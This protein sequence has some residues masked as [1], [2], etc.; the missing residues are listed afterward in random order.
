MKDPQELQLELSSVCNA[1]CAFCKR[2]EDLGFMDIEL[3]KGI[4]REF[5]E[6]KEI[7]PWFVGESM[8]H[9]RFIE[10]VEFI[11]SQRKRIV[12]YSNGSLL[13]EEKCEAMVS[14]G[15]DELRISVEGHEKQLYESLRIGLDFDTVRENIERYY[16]RKRKGMKLTVRVGIVPENHNQINEIVAFWKKR[17]DHVF[18][19]NEMPIGERD[20]CGEYRFNRCHQP[21]KRLVVRYNGEVALCCIDWFA[22]MGIGNVKESSARELWNSPRMD[23]LR[24]LANK[25]KALSLCSICRSRWIP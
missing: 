2:P 11:K 9:P 7:Q 1:R 13:D 12:L 23:E 15:V 17:A 3:F 18:T 14:V 22:D 6:S 4:I 25:P 5:P 16:H 19:M 8:L 10:A 21:S 20:V 24:Q